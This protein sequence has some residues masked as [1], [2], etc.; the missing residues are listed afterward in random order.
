MI[1]FKEFLA[2]KR[3][4]D[5]FLKGL[6][7]VAHTD[8]KKNMEYYKLQMR[9]KFTDDAVLDVYYNTLDWKYYDDYNA[10]QAIK[11]KEKGFRDAD[12]KKS[13]PKVKDLH[14]MVKAELKHRKI[15]F[16]PTQRPPELDKRIDAY[17]K[18]HKR[19]GWW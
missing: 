13:V 14:D 15:K 17:D 12:P 5:Q 11:D 10:K 8:K 18:K 1:R 9:K 19:V 4:P 3:G 7:R 2:E 16:H 6:W